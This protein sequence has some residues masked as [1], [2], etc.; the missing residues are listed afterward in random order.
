MRIEWQVVSQQVNVVTQQGVEASLADAGD[1]AIFAFPEIA[2]MNK[3]GVGAT[4]NSR[5]EQR[6]TG[7]NTSHETSD[8]GTSFHLQAIWAI[9]AELRGLQQLIQ[10]VHQF[11]T[12]H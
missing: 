6:L 7:G 10:I 3:D 12:F 9:I 4:F 5:V 8:L 1:A 2:M 11:F